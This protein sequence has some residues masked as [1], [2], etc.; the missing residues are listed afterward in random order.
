VAAKRHHDG[1]K[2]SF[3]MKVSSSSSS[4]HV[5]KSRSSNPQQKP[6]SLMVVRDFW[7]CQLFTLFVSVDKPK[8]G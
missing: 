4:S 8:R 7:G 1:N 3:M 5:G 2:D 6:V